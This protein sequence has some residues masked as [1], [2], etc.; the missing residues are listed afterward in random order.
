MT[1]YVNNGTC[2]TMGKNT[3]VNEVIINNTN[4]RSVVITGG[5]VYIDGKIYNGENNELENKEVVNLT[6]NVDGDMKGN[7]ESDCKVEINVRGAVIGNVNS[8]R[9]TSI[10]SSVLNGNVC[11]GR[12]TDISGDQNGEIRSGRNTYIEGC[13]K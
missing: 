11:S 1:N 4:G 2:V 10:E 13:V 7:V 3:K 9:D 6:I 8:G 5:K 12:D